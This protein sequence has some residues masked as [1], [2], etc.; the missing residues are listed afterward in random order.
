M[1]K[2]AEE[3]LANAVLMELQ[4][5]VGSDLCESNAWIFLSM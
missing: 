5:K 2:W 1:T 4:E 3:L